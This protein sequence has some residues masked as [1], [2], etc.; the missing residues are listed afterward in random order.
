VA[1]VCVEQSSWI[2]TGGTH[3]LPRLRIHHGAGRIGGTI[4]SICAGRQQRDS[5]RGVAE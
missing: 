4:T 2:T 1:V 5:R 3:R